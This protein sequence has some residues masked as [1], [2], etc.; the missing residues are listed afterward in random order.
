MDCILRAVTDCIASLDPIPKGY[1]MD[2]TRRSSREHRDVTYSCFSIHSSNHLS[3]DRCSSN[4]F[5]LYFSI[6]FPIE[7]AK[8][9]PL[10]RQV[11]N[12]HL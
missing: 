11:Q 8:S 10:T 7:D 6:F 9:D 5:R 1:M 3:L 2:I 4:G 12:S